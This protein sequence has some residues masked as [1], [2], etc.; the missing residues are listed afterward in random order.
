M[1]VDDPASVVTAYLQAWKAGDLSAL[2]E[3]LADDVTFIGP[4][5]TISGAEAFTEWLANLVKITRDI[6]IDKVFVDGPHVLT[7]YH[8]DTEVGLVG[9]VAN[10][11]Q[12][13]GGKITSIQVA[14]DPRPLINIW[15]AQ[16][17]Q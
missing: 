1:M 17:K 7:W 15:N 16:A 2:R 11:S 5:A 6:P 12:V 8:L 13:T 4:L 10:L 14:L 3:V 9:P